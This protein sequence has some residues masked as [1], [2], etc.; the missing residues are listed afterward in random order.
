MYR[1]DQR[2]RPQE[3]REKA[4]TNKKG[5]GGR[6]CRRWRRGTEHSPSGMSTHILLR[7]GM[8]YHLASPFLSSS[9]FPKITPPVSLRLFTSGHLTE[10]SVSVSV[11]MCVGLCVCVWLDFPNFADSVDGFRFPFSESRTSRFIPPYNKRSNN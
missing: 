7:V 2:H 9:S 8:P 11:C 3:E 6:F 4:S 1:N 10:V 5:R